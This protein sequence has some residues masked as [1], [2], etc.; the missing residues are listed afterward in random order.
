MKGWG[1]ADTG[2]ENFHILMMTQEEV[3]K[4][5]TET[6]DFTFAYVGI[7]WFSFHACH[8]FATYKKWKLYWIA[9]I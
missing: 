3:Y 8:E 7:S 4:V 2:S 6:L 5:E 1:S 9:F